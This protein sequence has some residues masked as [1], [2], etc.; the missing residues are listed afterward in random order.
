MPCICILEL[1]WLLFCDEIVSKTTPPTKKKAAV[2]LHL[3][4]LHPLK[5]FNLKEAQGI[6]VG[7]NLAFWEMY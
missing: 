4:E 5:G 1:D 6:T 7:M 3:D 2:K